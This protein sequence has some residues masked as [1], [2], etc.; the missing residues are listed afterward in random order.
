MSP[1]HYWNLPSPLSAETA[2]LAHD[3][4]LPE[5]VVRLMYQRGHRTTDAIQT[6]LHP[7]PA[8][9]NQPDK[10][11]DIKIATERIIAAL[12]THERICV[13]GDYDVDGVTG[14]T[15]L[16]STLKRLDAEVIYYLPHRRKEGYGL[17]MAGIDFCREQKVKLIITNDCGS[18]D[19][20]AI[21]AAQDAGIDTIVTD[22]HEVPAQLPPALAV[23]NPKRPDSSYPFPELAGVG[24]AFKLAWSVLATLG[25]PKSELT[26]LLDLVGLGTIA[27]MVPLIDENRIL[28]RIG[29]NVIR[30]TKRLGLQTLLEKTGPKKRRFTSHD[31]G[32]ILAPRLNAVGRIS[33]ASQA[34]R[35]LLTEDKNEAEQ[36]VAELE[37]DNHARQSLEEKIV[38]QAISLVESQG[39]DKKKVLVVAQEGWHEG[40]IGLVASKLVERYY[41]PAIVI[42]LKDQSGKGSGR[43]ISGFNLY[44]SFQA[45]AEYLVKFGGHKCA[46][47]LQIER[48]CIPEFSA[49][50]NRFA[51]ELPEEIYRPCLNIDAVINLNE[52][53]EDFIRFLQQLEPFGSENPLPLFASLGLE[54]VGYPRRIG[55]NHLKMKLR[56]ENK[57]LPA[58][59][60]Q[61]SYELPK[62]EVGR[63]NH[64]DIC[65][66]VER[67]TYAGST[68]TQL[69]LRD[70]RTHLT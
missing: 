62:L 41:R 16:V 31:I 40:V 46:G 49:A 38:K 11:P 67:R 20:E 15:L 68:S 35:L 69:N 53:D 24:V 61:R 37:A 58:I 60:W 27:D 3:L 33:H 57:V 21:A 17:S 29:L 55:K 36:L 59:A 43:S 51:D 47:G 45:C 70:L 1:T 19:R 52:I 4:K 23:V 30:N 32:F 14:T 12:D 65:Y 26:D 63:K 64:L 54:V 7:S 5:L 18:T 13:Y 22:H 42:A 2:R 66:T 10:L 6:F 44:A 34:V 8:N 9:L 48:N 56:S 25:R 50:I 39:L 28:A